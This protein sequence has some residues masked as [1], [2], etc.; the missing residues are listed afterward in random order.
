MLVKVIDHK[1]KACWVNPAYVRA[2][3]EKGGG[4]AAIDVSGW[5]T[6]LVVNESM[7]E[8]A[9][10]LAI[11]MERTAR[12]SAEVA[13]RSVQAAAAHQTQA[14]LVTSMIIIGG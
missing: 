9:G 6:P 5:P 14:D 3:R 13:E 12:D 8:V 11:A 7:D 2:V 1:G 10:L 4:K